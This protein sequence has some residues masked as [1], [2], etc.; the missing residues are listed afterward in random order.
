MLASGLLE[1]RVMS[2]PSDG[3]ISE[4]PPSE[5]AKFTSS[6]C[7]PTRDPGSLAPGRHASRNPDPSSLPS[8]W[9]AALARVAV[10]PQ[11]TDPILPQTPAP[12]H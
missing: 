9:P 4:P 10:L 5:Q 6:F 7:L 2:P 11:R 1:S 12:V 3:E 8:V